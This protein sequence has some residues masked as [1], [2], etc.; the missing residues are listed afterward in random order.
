MQ[1]PQNNSIPEQ[2]REVRILIVI[3]VIDEDRPKHEVHPDAHRPAQCKDQD[4]VQPGDKAIAWLVFPSID[5]V[6][7][8]WPN[9]LMVA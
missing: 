2:V 4:P 7:P 6:R 8:S 9:V 3:L 5:S 1:M